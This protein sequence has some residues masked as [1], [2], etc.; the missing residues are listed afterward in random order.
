MVYKQTNRFLKMSKQKDNM[1]STTLK[2]S[3]G[4]LI[5][6]NK[7][8][9]QL[10]KLF[11]ENLEE[12]QPV[13]V[14]FD[15]NKDDGSLAQLAKIHKCI[16]EIAKETGDSYEDMKLLIKKKAGLCVKKEIEGEIIMHCKSFGNASKTDLAMVIETIIQ[17]GD[18]VGVNCR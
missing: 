4:K 16:R 13:E 9:E 5:Y 11:L 15:A 3:N 2:K 12:D 10:F 17:I 6:S 8:E 14:F 1:F 7:S 18:L